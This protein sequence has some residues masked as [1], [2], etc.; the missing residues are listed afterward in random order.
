MNNYRIYQMETTSFC[1]AKCPWCP[2]SSLTRPSGFIDLETVSRV[3]AH[4]KEV[5]QKYIALH[6]MGEP[7]MHPDF[8]KILEMFNDADIKVEFSTNAILLPKHTQAIIMNN[9]AVIRIAVDYFGFHAEYDGYFKMLNEQMHLFK[10]KNTKV[11]LHTV[12]KQ[13]VNEMTPLR[14]IKYHNPWVEIHHK[15]MDNWAGQVDGESTLPPGECYFL[16]KNHV[17]VLWNGDIV[18]C[19]M[20]ADGRHV[21]GNIN[22]NP[23]ITVQNKYTLCQSCVGMQFAQEGGWK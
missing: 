10:G 19:C 15:D 21:L 23:E 8:V 12:L 20:D 3:I 22:V 13:Y 17:V 6:H 16:T 2:H 5:N 1:N 14:E 18:P 9:V 11:Y 4:C 7:L